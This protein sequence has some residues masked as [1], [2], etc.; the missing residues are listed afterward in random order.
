L[1]KTNRW[2]RLSPALVSALLIAS[3]FIAV[4]IAGVIR[5]SLGAPTSAGAPSGVSSQ[6]PPQDLIGITRLHR[7]LGD[8]TPIGTGVIAGH[9]EGVAGDY[10]P[11]IH[12]EALGGVRLV[13][14]SGVSRIND[15]AT[16]T[17]RVIYGPN[18]MAPGI[19]EVH[20]YHV[21]DFLGR[22]FLRFG[23][24]YQPG[25][26]EPRLFNHSWIGNDN[27][28]A[29]EVLARL[30]DAIDTHDVVMV[31]GVNNGRS[32][33]V[34]AL[35]ASAYN[36][37][38]V[39]QWDGDSSGGY[40]RL[41]TP[42][43]CKPD[44]VGPGS[45]TSFS[46]PAVTGVVAR[47]LE[48]AGAMSEHPHAT[49]AELIK[50]VLLAGASKPANWRPADGRPLDEHLGAGRADAVAS[51]AILTAGP[52]QQHGV[53]PRR[54]WCFDQLPAGGS[55]T[56]SLF[57][58]QQVGELSLVLVWHRRGGD[59]R[60]GD[61]TNVYWL[62]RPRV[63]DFDLELVRVDET[64]VTTTI[65][66]S[67][68]R[69]DNVEHIYRTGAGAGRYRVTVSRRDRDEQPWDYALAWRVEDVQTTLAAR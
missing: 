42:G 20:H 55:R 63:A 23:S 40:T 29:A 43:R 61:R 32:S 38:A 35:L 47:L 5:T 8:E 52:P 60:D 6:A 14:V 39:G 3:V 51:Y 4:R 69:I 12:T 37:I 24:A 64:H 13:A 16:A 21:A 17:A 18:G 15:H 65:A 59:L 46:T 1:A 33:R 25:S 54:G 56:Y 34:P 53:M 50:A 68:S 26:N 19:G 41:E 28:T 2:L 27:G 7:L 48:A 66:K 10:M 9:V 67:A 30:D 44:I 49:R 45:R 58:P 57:L 36:A 62:P 22:E 11:S 31:V